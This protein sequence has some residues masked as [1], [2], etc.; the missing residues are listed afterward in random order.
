M[1]FN[2]P[3]KA[4]RVGYQYPA[5]T[6]NYLIEDFILVNARAI[7]TYLMLQGAVPNTFI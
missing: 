5:D 4:L 6:N 3:L 2:S 1:H 7:F